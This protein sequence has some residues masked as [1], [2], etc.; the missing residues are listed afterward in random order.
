M[1]QEL[2]NSK[3]IRELLEV[4]EDQQEPD[5]VFQLFQRLIASRDEFLNSSQ[6]INEANQS[7]VSFKLHKLKNQFANLGCEAVSH[8]LEEMYQSARNHNLQEVRNSLPEL[9]SLSDQTFQQLSS[10]L[11]H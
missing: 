10:K 3:Y 4:T 9:R 2:I 7:E 11:K 6:E 1:E 8:L 5:L